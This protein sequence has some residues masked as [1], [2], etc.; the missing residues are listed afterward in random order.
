MPSPFPWSTLMRQLGE[1]ATYTPATG[2]PVTLYAK[3]I[4]GG[5]EVAV[6]SVRLVAEDL[7]AHVLRADL[8]TPAAGDTL[9][10]GAG[11]WTVGAV[12]PL[13]DDPQ[14]TRWALRL[15]WGL[16]VTIRAAGGADGAGL[17]RSLAYTAAPAP[18]GAT[19]LTIQVGGWTAGGLQAGDTL[20][21]GGE[22]YE[23]TAGTTLVFVGGGY[24]F[25]GVAID[26]P[27]SDPLAGGEVVTI[28][29]AAPDGARQVFAAPAEWTAEEVAGGIATSDQRLVIRAA[30]GLAAPTTSDEVVLPGETRGRAVTSVRTI[31]TGADVAAWVVTVAG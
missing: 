24:A 14:A 15:T 13:A 12:E 23:V 1:P 21:V 10:L 4:G 3:R 9:A 7:T 17:D 26:P 27:L 16:L 29:P 6:G 11:T 19:S 31:H 22:E 2:A 30:P 5:R 8:P 18:A 20:A 25:E 28:T